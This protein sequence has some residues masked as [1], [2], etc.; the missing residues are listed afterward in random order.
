MTKSNDPQ[1]SPDAPIA[2]GRAAPTLARSERLELH[3]FMRLARE[4]DLRFEK[5]FKTGALSKW[6]SSVGNEATT[7]AAAT[8]IEAGDTLC[9]LHRDAGAIIRH[10]VDPEQLFPGLLPEGPR[11]P[12]LDTDA[13]LLLHRLACQMLGRREGF[14]NGYERSYHYNHFDE[15]VGLTHIGMISHLGS[16]IPVAAGAALA[17]QHAGRDRVAINFIGE[18]ATSTGDFHEGLNIA[19]VW[20]LPFI[21]VIENNQWAF[22]TPASQQYA[23]ASLAER[24]AAY[25]IP[26]VQ[27]DG[28]DPEAVLAVMRTAVERARAGEGPTLVEA[29]LGR[30]RGHSEGD[31]SMAQLSDEERQEHLAHD[32]LDL[33]E[34]ALAEE[35]I[36]DAEHFERVRK[37]CHDLWI[38]VVDGA[39][40][41]AEPDVTEE[42]PIHAD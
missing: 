20:R 3:L 40:A 13:R 32:P 25:G 35:G 31:D 2:P 26:G 12:P 37:A 17:H 14:S 5:M 18:G 1:R 28:N 15:R 39:A 34:S 29:M 42:R 22:S 38:D 24:G 19:A 9:S 10:Y 41:T 8:A 36:G 21:L 4:W 16:M 7:V 33:Y 6:Y 11:R 30:H 27:V 23:C